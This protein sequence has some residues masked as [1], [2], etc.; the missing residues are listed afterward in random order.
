MGS[1]R[2]ANLKHNRAF[3][4]AVKATKDA[5]ATPVAPAGKKTRAA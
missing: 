1:L 5:K 2:T 3:A 4:Y